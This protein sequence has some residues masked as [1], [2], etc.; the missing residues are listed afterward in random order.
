M[1]LRNLLPTDHIREWFHHLHQYP[2]LSHQEFKTADYIHEALEKIGVDEIIR[3][4]ATSLIATIQ[5]FKPGKTVMFRADIDALPITEE[6]GL[7]FASKNPGVMHACGHDTHTAML[8]GTA[9]VLTQL[10]S[11][12]AGTV[13]LLFQHAEEVVPSG[14]KQIIETGAL[15]GISAG[16]GMH[17]LIGYPAGA[18][19]VVPKG[20]ASSNTDFFNIKIRGKGTHASTP[21]MGIDPI[22][23][24]AEIILT[25]QTIVSRSIAPDETAVVTIGAIQ[26]GTANNIIP[27]TADIKGNVRTINPETRAFVKQRVETI[28]R[29]ICAAHGADC[30]FEYQYGIGMM[31]NDPELSALAKAACRKVLNPEMVQDAKA[32]LGSEDFAYFCDEFPCCYLFFSGG[33]EEDGCIYTTHH[34]KFHIVEEVLPLGTLAQVQILL[35]ALA[36]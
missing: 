25:L 24:A 34:P 35:D 13:K 30:D 14:A 28:V 3:P 18:I 11:T 15:K 26:A 7:P 4:T 19:G 36:N 31:I 2:E 10:R 5:G 12:F 20:H 21:H 9:E 32:M 23:I 1:D 22:L 27:D 8:L 33:G 16:F 6:T 17:T 29:S